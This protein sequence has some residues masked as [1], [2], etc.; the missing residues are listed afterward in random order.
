M[1]FTEQLYSV[2][3]VCASPKLS[4]ALLPL[5]PS[6][7]YGVVDFVPRVSAARRMLRERSYDFVIVNASS[8]SQD[9]AIAFASEVCGC[10][11]TAALLLVPAG[12]DPDISQRATMDGVFVLTKPT[13]V[14]MLQL[15]LRFLAAS[16]ERLRRLEENAAAMERKAEDLRLINRAKWLLI[17][18]LKMSEAVAHRYIEKQAMDRCVTRREIALNIIRTYE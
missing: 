7:V 9:P 5:L 17:E 14:Q 3:V 4:E 16:R 12:T 6:G 1:V 10:A 13:S 18:N 8:V 11:G 2:M 15:S